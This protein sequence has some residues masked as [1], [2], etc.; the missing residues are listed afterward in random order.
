MWACQCRFVD[1]VHVDVMHYTYY[2]ST[3]VKSESRYVLQAISYTLGLV[4]RE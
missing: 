2:E 1:T 4:G 3:F